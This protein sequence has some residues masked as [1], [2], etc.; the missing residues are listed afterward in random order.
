M[1][2]GHV[3]SGHV[4]PAAAGALPLFFDGSA[5]ITHDADLA[6]LDPAA[7]ITVVDP[8][9]GFNSTQYSDTISQ[10]I[11]ESSGS[12]TGF[13][14]LSHFEA[15]GV[16]GFDSNGIGVTQDDVDVVQVF[17]GAASLRIDFS[18]TWDF[19]SQFGPAPHLLHQRPRS[20]VTSGAGTGGYVQL[21]I[22]ATALAVSGTANHTW[23]GTLYVNSTPGPFSYFA[24]VAETELSD[25]FAESDFGDEEGSMY[26]HIEFIAR[27]GTL[28]GSSISYGG[29]GLLTPEPSSVLLLGLGLGCL[30]VSRTRKR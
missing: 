10:T 25:F 2:P 20:Q 22:V 29:A 27:S 24:G 7:A 5:T 14:G 6:D 9:P 19:T 26:G 16:F 15:P 18:A 12:S 13:G 30:G 21:D 17:D 28:G 8:L 11:D 4:W 1:R 23:G 3:T